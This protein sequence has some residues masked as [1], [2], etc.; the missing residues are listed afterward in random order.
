MPLPVTSQYAPPQ[1]WEEFES[2]CCDLYERLWNDRSTQKHGRQ[3]QPQGGVDV[4]GRPDGHNY[5]GVQCKKKAIWPPTDLTIAEIDEE[6]AKA[7]TWKP[8]LKQYIV[9]TTAPN[10]D[11]VQA[12]A[13]G[14]TALHK[15]KRLFSV[16]IASWDQITRQLANYPDLLR[17]YGYITDIAETAKLVA[18]HLRE[19]A[20]I[21]SATR[22]LATLSHIAG[23]EPALV[24]A[25]ERDLA[26][27]FTRAMRRSFFPETTLVD[28][29]VSVA[30]IASEPEYAGV[31]SE[32]RR[33]ILL[34]A[35]RSAAVRGTLEKAQ[36][37]LRQAQKLKGQDSDL[38]ARAR[39]L[40]KTDIDGALSL[41]RDETDADS[42]S[43]VFNMLVRH[44]RPAVGLQW[45]AEMG[46][47]VA[48]LT[49]NGLQTLVTAHLQSEDFDGLRLR[50][51]EVTPAQLSE[52]P[53]FRF[54]RAMVAVA[55]ILPVPD[56]ELA[57]RSFQ[58]D[59][60]RGTRSILDDVTTA[61]RLDQAIDDLTAL[62]PLAAELE[63]PHAKR[64]AEAYILWCELLHPHRKSAGLNRLRGELKD[65]KLARERLSL[66]FAFD[67]NFKPEALDEYL[68]RR[69][70]LG[71]LDS[72]DLKAALII[73]IHSDDPASVA[74]LISR[75]RARFEADYKDP[76]IFTI[77]IQALALAGDTSSA[78]ILFEEHREELTSDGVAM[79]DALIA[80]CEGKDPVAEDLKL[81]EATKSLES[82]R[83][84]VGSLS[85]RKDHRATAKYSE[86]LFAQSSDPRDIARAAYAFAYLGDGPEFVRII[87]ANSQ[88]PRS[89][90]ASSLRLGVIQTGPLEGSQ[91]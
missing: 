87:E 82:L 1:S 68:K 84:L 78:R 31:S 73:R 77:E 58:M 45:L 47:S 54:V 41:I 59:A 69:E 2:L 75:Y 34:R 13:R 18:V 6:V 71:G 39:I 53:Y 30:D 48:Q 56:R 28:E 33:R 46:T 88:G 81:Y 4:Y 67:P 20:P 65:P 7:K 72:E 36:E 27:R 43:S 74:S 86:D 61:S 91:G 60:R 85:G 37:L 42:R 17:K 38:L 25:V 90:I 8:G 16:E 29:Y 40:E 3:G 62:L 23:Q 50:L 57:V 66:A 55:S 52:G 26:S 76:P 11:K 83:T 49:I 44:R 32:L 22:R 70:E 12:H 10:D 80:K 79:F 89:R 64:L 14:L 51:E 9:A 15:R 21:Q 24:E 5:A 35:A 19:T 63:L